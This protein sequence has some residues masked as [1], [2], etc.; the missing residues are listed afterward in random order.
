MKILHH[1]GDHNVYNYIYLYICIINIHIQ[2]LFSHKK[3]KNPCDLWP[4]KKRKSHMCKTLWKYTQE[5]V[6]SEPSLNE[7]RNFS[8][9]YFICSCTVLIVHHRKV[10]FKNKLTHKTYL[11]PKMWLG[12]KILILLLF[13]EIRNLLQNNTLNWPNEVNH[14]IGQWKK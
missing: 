10:L 6:N 2:I 14:D 13:K 7:Q 5:T 11:Y 4:K 1:C 8:L 3:K 9:F 12:K